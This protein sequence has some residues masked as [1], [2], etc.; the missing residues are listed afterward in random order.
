LENRVRHRPTAFQYISRRNPDS[1]YALPSQIGVTPQITSGI[2]THIVRNPI[3]LDRKLRLRAK[4]IDNIGTKGMLP[5]YFDAIRL[6]T[7]MPP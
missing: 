3:D 1:F 2:V 5:A 4:E 7:K 6:L